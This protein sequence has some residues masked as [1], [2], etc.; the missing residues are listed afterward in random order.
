MGTRIGIWLDHRHA[1]IVSLAPAGPIV[2]KVSSGMPGH[3][4]F[5]GSQVG[6]GEQKYEARHVHE[7]THFYDEIIALL[8]QPTGILILGPGEA[9]REF[10]NRLARVRR[11][12]DVPVDVEAA[13]SLT[14]AQV[15][16]RVEEHFDSRPRRWRAAAPRV[17]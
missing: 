4:H 8:E 2:K 17:M 1:V 9:K 7:L 12:M 13:D 6:G 16:A 11:L 10:E 14:E 3:P 5:G 15:V